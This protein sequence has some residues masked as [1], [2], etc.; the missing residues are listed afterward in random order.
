[1]SIF[2]LGKDKATDRQVDVAVLEAKKA[3]DDVKLAVARFLSAVGS[4]PLDESIVSIGASLT[5]K[6]GKT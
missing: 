5:E 4:I 6:D 3:T 1:M 2:R